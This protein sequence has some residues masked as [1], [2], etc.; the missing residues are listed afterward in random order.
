MASAVSVFLFSKIVYP[1]PLT[2]PDVGDRDCSLGSWKVS[3]TKK[4][5]QQKSIGF[6]NKP[7]RSQ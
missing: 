6:T 1:W 7:K 2:N 3:L 5:D 4:P